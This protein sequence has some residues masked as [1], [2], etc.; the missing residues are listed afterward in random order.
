MVSRIGSI[1]ITFQSLVVHRTER[2]K[3]AKQIEKPFGGEDSNGPNEPHIRWRIGAALVG[4]IFHIVIHSF[5]HICLSIKCNTK[6]TKT[7]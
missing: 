1:Y 4:G 5:I 7:E 3:T 6:F 2:A